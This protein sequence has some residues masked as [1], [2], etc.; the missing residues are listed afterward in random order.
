MDK[1]LESEPISTGLEEFG[2]FYD[3]ARQ[4]VVWQERL[5]CDA[6]SESC[7]AIDEKIQNDDRTFLRSCGVKIE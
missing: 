6:N 5:S 3:R 2:L 1:S 7:R 4:C